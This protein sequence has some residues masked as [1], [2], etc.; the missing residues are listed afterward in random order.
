MLHCGP[1]SDG[2]FYSDV[3]LCHV[4]LHYGSRSGLPLVVSVLLAAGAVPMANS[5]GKKPKD[6]AMSPAIAKLFDEAE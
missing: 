2:D 1:H 6:L 5:D 4:A 3:W